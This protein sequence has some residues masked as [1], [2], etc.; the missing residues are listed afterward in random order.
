[1]VHLLQQLYDACKEAFALPGLAPS[2]QLLQQV[3]SL[4]DAMTLADLG[5]DE[6]FFVQVNKGAKSPQTVFYLHIHMCR[7]FS[8]GI[9]YLPQS[10]VIPLHDHPEM[11]VLNKLLHGSMHVKAYDWVDPS[12]QRS[13]FSGQRSEASFPNA[14]LARLVVEDIFTAPCKASMFC[15]TGGGNIHALT[16]VTHCAVLDVLAPPYSAAEERPCTYYYD[17]PT[18]CLSEASAIEGTDQTL[19]WLEVR[20]LPYDNDFI[21]RKILRD[22]NFCILHSSRDWRSFLEW[23]I[24]GVPYRISW[25]LPHCKVLF[26]G[27]TPH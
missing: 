4:I 20:Q 16:G 23:P 1:M 12:V 21:G 26:G 10:A 18:D 14:R 3:Q 9:F 6:E 7:R 27:L 19:A 25:A 8:M 2:P 13:D 5:L 22:T 11:T 15:P 17:F 24:E